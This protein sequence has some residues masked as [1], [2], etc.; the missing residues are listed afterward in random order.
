MASLNIATLPL[1]LA[2]PI[3][4]RVDRTSATIWFVLKEQKTISFEVY[5]DTDLVASN[6]STGVPLGDHLFL[7]CLTATAGSEVTSSQ[8]VPIS[9]VNDFDL[10]PQKYRYNLLDVSVG[11]A[12]ILDGL[13]IKYEGETLPSFCL[14]AAI[15]Q[16]TR[17]IH[18]S[19][20]KPHGEGY[21]ALLKLDKLLDESFKDNTTRPQQLFLTG[22]QIYADDV[23]SDILKRIR[24]F[25]PELFGWTEKVPATLASFFTA[26][27]DSEDE[28]DDDDAEKLNR[29]D[30]K[31]TIPLVDKMSVIQPGQGLSGLPNQGHYSQNHILSFQEFVMMYILVWS[32]VLWDAIP[33]E[34][35]WNKN[36]Y[37][38]HFKSSLT[39]IRR[40]LANI[41]TYTAFDDHDVTNGWNFNYQWCKEVYSRPFGRRVVFNGLLAY[42][43]CQAWGNT[44][45]HF[46]STADPL[47]T[48]FDTI[49]TA[50]VS[51]ET[52]H[53]PTAELLSIPDYGTM[54]NTN[55]NGT[56]LSPQG[57]GLSWHY[58]LA[59]DGVPYDVLVLDSR[60]M[61][62]FPAG[63]GAEFAG[64]VSEP[65]YQ[66][67]VDLST[68]TTKDILFAV[69]GTPAIGM[70]WLE[71]YQ[72]SRANHEE[73]Y[74]KD[75]EALVLNE[76]SYL[77]FFSNLAR[78]FDL[79]AAAPKK[80][81]VVLSGDVHFGFTAKAMLQNFSSANPVIN[82]GRF[83]ED[84]NARTN[85]AQINFV[86]CTS[87]S[88]KNQVD[89]WVFWNL[90][91]TEQLHDHGYFVPS[92]GPILMGS[93]A[94]AVIFRD[95]RTAPLGGAAVYVVD[96]KGRLPQRSLPDLFD[97]IGSNTQYTNA[98][99]KATHVSSDDYQVQRTSVNQG[100]WLFKIEYL[101]GKDFQ[102]FIEGRQLIGWNTIGEINFN[103]DQEGKLLSHILHWSKDD[104]FDNTT[105]F[106]V[107]II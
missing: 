74:G 88:I 55:A 98:S 83:F 31:I 62:E 9:G 44:P 7:F 45:A 48:D 68:K 106:E 43:Y 66:L 57:G 47:I 20:R 54:G 14:P 95:F 90:E 51:T 52:V 65:G 32:N 60:T 79:T 49:K 6:R 46:E 42:A 75:T 71:W 5:K 30:K 92:F 81:V 11:R 94:C 82:G 78:K 76:T 19:C 50:M 63:G 21:D 4:R 80:N 107:E 3:V 70:P 73:R 104:G 69:L 61:R 64:L 87:S 41:S 40:A 34:D 100:E 96:H 59:Y 85:T 33:D 10:Y 97:L 22:D 15:I 28:K 26:N 24:F 17:I 39:Q 99:R 77:R 53:T 86:Q 36:D 67:Q 58:Y 56:A 35:E 89:A 12:S 29:N 101:Q 27:P 25:I 38:D 93:A 103:S 105:H 8:T 16:N 1:I 84:A 18:G 102:V 13:A 37:I 91:A 23:S 2:G 72:S